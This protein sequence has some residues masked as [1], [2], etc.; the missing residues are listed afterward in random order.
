MRKR[1]LIVIAAIAVVATAAAIMSARDSARVAHAGEPLF[2]ALLENINRV[3]QVAGTSGGETFTLVHEK[4]RWIV[5]EKLGY[6]ADQTKVRQ[7]VLGAAQLERIEPK[8]SNPE[9]YGELGLGDADQAGGKAVHFVL[10]DAAGDAL[11]EFVVGEERPARG[12]PQADEYYVREPS[13]PQSWLV[14]G[15]IAIER[16]AL[17]W[18]DQTVLSLA[19]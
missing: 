15:K 10:E 1:T 11:A 12:D 17:D 18:L 6:P 7:L 4:G 19:R 3:V 8:T 16:N 9:L 14:Q 5:P 2:P 13:D